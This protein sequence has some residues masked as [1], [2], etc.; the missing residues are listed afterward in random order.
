M[1]QA[2]KNYN[3]RR[4]GLLT[5]SYLA[6]KNGDLSLEREV[7][8]KIDKFNRSA[9]GSVNPITGKTKNKSFKT[10]EKLMND[11]VGGISLNKSVE[12]V[13]RRDMGS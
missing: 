8:E 13:I 10:R 6:R 4:S 5:M 2:E 3:A 1:K 9:L 12:D 7:Q 11:S